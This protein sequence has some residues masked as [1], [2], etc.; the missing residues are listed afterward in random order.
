MAA[1]GRL[2]AEFKDPDLERRFRA[3][4]LPDWRHQATLALFLAAI[5]FLAFIVTDH[6][7][8]GWSHPSYVLGGLRLGTLAIAVAFFVTTRIDRRFSAF[9]RAVFIA[10]MGFAAIYCAIIALYP[11]RLGISTSLAVPLIVGA[12]LFVPNRAVLAV[13]AGAIGSA[14]FVAAASGMA[15]NASELASV[16]IELTMLNVVGGVVAFRLHRMQRQRFAAVARERQINERLEKQSSKLVKLASRLAKARDEADHANRAKSEF[17]AHMSHELRTPLNAING[18]S[19]IIKDE[20]FGPVAPRYRSYATDILHSGLHLTALINDVLDLSKIEAGKLDIDEGIV[21]L[22]AVV[23]S[24]LHLIHD[25]ADKTDLRLCTDLPRDLP[26]LRADERLVKQMLLN[27]LTNA[28]KFTPAGGRVDVSA[29]VTE[30]G[31]LAFTVHDTGVGI[32]PHDLPR[33]LEPYGQVA[34]TRKHNPDG[35]GLGLPLIKRMIEL[36]GGT[37]ELDSIPTVGTIATVVFPA[38]RVMPGNRRTAFA[39]VG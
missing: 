20:M 7:R 24:C 14:A 34:T 32:A 8:F 6:W 39:K 23:D 12:Q 2:T 31:D 21:E 18:F 3:E 25:R 37:L 1:I 16:I 30:S 15:A 28:V 27:L 11:Y 10:E 4:M 22:A 13:S 9:T 38:A 17:L 19:E 35:T 26:K 5:S 29:R 36:H 33:V